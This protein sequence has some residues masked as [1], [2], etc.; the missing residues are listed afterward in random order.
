MVVIGSACSGLSWDSSIRLGRYRACA[1]RSR[2]A[3]SKDHLHALFNEVEVVPW[4]SHSTASVPGRLCRSADSAPGR[5]KADRL[6]QG[7]QV[8]DSWYNRTAR[9]YRTPHSRSIGRSL[10]VPGS[11]SPLS[12][13]NA[14]PATA[15]A[16]APL[17][18][19]GTKSVQGTTNLASS[20]GR[21]QA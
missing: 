13:R 16:A 4:W 8:S 2:E 3:H 14:A 6:H 15:S 9:Q 5:T 17:A 10:S 21:H 19:R 7:K 20:S 12:S 18:P 1:A 11:S